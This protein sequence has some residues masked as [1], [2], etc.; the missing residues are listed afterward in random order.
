LYKNINAIRIGPNNGAQTLSLSPDSTLQEVFDFI[1]TEDHDV[2]VLP[3][4]LSKKEDK[5]ARMM[6]IIQGKPNT[7]NHI[8]ANLMTAVQ[9]MFDQAEQHAASKPPALVDSTGEPLTDDVKLDLPAAN[10]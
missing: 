3:V 2:Q 10:Q 8:M 9:D 7:A 6:I 4:T 1:R 5:W